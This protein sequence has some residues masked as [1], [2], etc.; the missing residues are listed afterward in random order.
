VTAENASIIGGLGEGVAAVLGENLPVPMI[1]V[2]VD[3]EFSQSGRITPEIDELK[4]HFAFRAEDLAVSVREVIA[5]KKKL[6][7]GSK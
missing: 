2:G 4:V 7:A 5:R 1:R 6:A 3:D